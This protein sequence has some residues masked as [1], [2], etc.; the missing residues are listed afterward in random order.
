MNT[1]KKL[2]EELKMINKLFY[3]KDRTTA[4]SKEIKTRKKE[5]KKELIMLKIQDLDPALQVA[6]G[7]RSTIILN[8]KVIYNYRTKKVKFKNYDKEYSI[9]N[10]EDL[11]EYIN[12]RW[13]NASLTPKKLPTLVDTLV[14]TLQKPE[15]AKIIAEVL[16]KEM[17]Q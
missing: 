7:Y 6:S 3:S 17:Y 4:P 16:N 2:Q 12:T 10:E 5:I 11:V 9:K 13:N 1:A 14:T 15:V 8:D